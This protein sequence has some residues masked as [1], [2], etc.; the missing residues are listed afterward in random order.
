MVHLIRNAK[1]SFYRKSIQ[2]NLDNPKNLWKI[3][4]NIAPFKCSNLPSHLTV[5]SVTY[6]DS[7]DISNIFNKH[8]VNIASSVNRNTSSPVDHS[9][10]YLVDF[11]SSKFSENSSFTIPPLS[12][13]FVLDK[14][15]HLSSNKASGL[16][17]LN[18]HFLKIAASSISP[19]LTKI[20][21]LSIATGIF[22]NLWKIAKVTPLFKDG[23]LF[24]CSN[25]R[26]ISV[27]SIISKIIER[28]VHDSFYSYLT[29]HDLLS[30]CQFGFRKFRSCELAVTE[31]SDK[32]LTNIDKGLLNGALLIDL[33]KAF[34]LVDH[35]MLLKKLGIYGSSPSSMQWFQ[36]Y[37]SDRWSAHCLQGYLV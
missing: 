36:S 18:S 30:D 19:S 3:I 8:F 24:E 31:L 21:N 10:D 15:Q 5:D 13:D 7:F 11:I 26:P 16:D 2:S 25:Y 17:G 34:D 9:L 14:L 6:T 28:H 29:Q 27:L 4:R 22:P 37:L 32:L 1:R 35:S 12:D 33:K 23:S 20:L